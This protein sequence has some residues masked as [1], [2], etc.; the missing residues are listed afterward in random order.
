MKRALYVAAMFIAL[1]SGF[2]AAQTKFP[3]TIVCN[4][5]DADVYINNT[6]Y[7]KTR[8]NLA[9]QLP[10]ATYSVKIAKAGFA[11]FNATVAVTNKGAK[12]SVTLQKLAQTPTPT[13]TPTPSPFLPQ[14]P[15]NVTANV[16]GA[17]V[18]LN[19]KLVGTTPYGANVTGGT[20]TVVVKAPGYGDFSQRLQ[21]NGPQQVNATLQPTGV[22]L[23][24][25]ANVPN[26]QVLLNGNPAGNA[27]FSSQVPPGSYTVTV[28]APGYLDYNQNI[29]VSGPSQVNAVLQPVTYALTVNANV[30]GADVII[31][32]SALG[33]VPYSALALAG[34]YTIVVRA[35]GYDDYSQTIVVSGPV[36]VNALLQPS[37]ASW[38]VS[39]PEALVNKSLKG[40]HWNQIQIYVDGVLQKG[41]LGQ[42]LPGKHLLRIVS[43][44]LS[45]ETA[46]D[47]LAGKQYSIEPAMGFVIKQN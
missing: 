7:T 45:Y 29:V 5:N 17:E 22:A 35:P 46:I 40:G 24:I 8:P 36:Q 32:G 23:T 41:D 15:L 27:P 3:L 18:Y 28:R 19:S 9:I 34:G 44:G 6:L 4:E 30:A 13:P 21:V 43:G 31:N 25:S 38:K 37:Q 1:A 33:K 2:L 14:F 10:V 42:V 16:P 11:E 39:I 47:F 12:L 20:Y 26:A